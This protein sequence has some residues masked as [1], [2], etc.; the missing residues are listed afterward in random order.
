MSCS[1]LVSTRRPTVLSLPF[2]ARLPWLNNYWNKRQ[3]TLLSFLPFNPRASTTNL[4]YIGKV[5]FGRWRGT[6]ADPSASPSWSQG[7]ESN[8][9][10]QWDRKWCLC[11]NQNPFI[12]NSLSFKSGFTW[13]KV[14]ILHWENSYYDFNFNNF[15]CN[16][17]TSNTYLITYNWFLFINDLTFNSKLKNIYVKLLLLLL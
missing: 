14:S 9:C 15:T 5:W 16:I 13:P 6:V 17:N 11:D 8:S 12:P 4:F 1:K 10:Y 2:S 7:F 3:R